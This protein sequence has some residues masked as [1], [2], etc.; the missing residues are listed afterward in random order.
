[1]LLTLE[2]GTQVVSKYSQHKYK[3][4][5]RDKFCRFSMQLVEWP[6]LLYCALVLFSSIKFK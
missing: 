3:S 1:M 5:L 6:F 4:N 2:M